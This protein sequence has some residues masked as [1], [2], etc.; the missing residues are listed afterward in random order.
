VEGKDQV[1][2][3]KLPDAVV[4][5]EEHQTQ[6]EDA[7]ETREGRIL[8]GLLQKLLE[9]D[10]L[11]RAFSPREAGEERRLAQTLLEIADP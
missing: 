6:D 4:E 8:S 1:L 7:R 11:L 9:E 5:D 10:G 2:D 3:V